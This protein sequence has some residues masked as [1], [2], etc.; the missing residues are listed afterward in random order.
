M[1]FGGCSLYWIGDTLLRDGISG[2]APVGRWFV[3]TRVLVTL[4]VRWSRSRG[5]GAAQRLALAGGALLTYIWVGF[6]RVREMDV[7]R[8]TG[9]LGNVAFVAGA[10]SSCWQWPPAPVTVKST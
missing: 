2:W 7:P 1:A 5:W 10:H 6:L 8:A 4:C 9:V 3:L